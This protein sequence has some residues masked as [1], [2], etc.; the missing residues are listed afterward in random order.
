MYI[1]VKVEIQ[2][3]RDIIDLSDVCNPNSDKTAN[4]SENLSNILIIIQIP[5]FYNRYSTRFIIFQNLHMIIIYY[6]Y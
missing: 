1:I 3:N 2:E 4:S 5:L 6:P